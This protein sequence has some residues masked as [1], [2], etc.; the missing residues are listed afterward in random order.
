MMDIA[1]GY[2]APTD[3][4]SGGSTGRFIT[5]VDQVLRIYNQ[6]PAFE[7]RALLL[8]KGTFTHRLWDGIRVLLEA[9]VDFVNTI[10]IT[11]ILMLLSQHQYFT[12]RTA[13]GDNDTAHSVAYGLLYSW[14]IILAVAANCYTGS[15]TYGLVERAIGKNARVLPISSVTVGLR[16]RYTNAL[17]WRR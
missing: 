2:D 8:Q 5:A 6:R 10:L 17:R 15:L 13:L 12:T 7:R 9:R 14:P 16:Y 3:L 11:V 1:E 4:S